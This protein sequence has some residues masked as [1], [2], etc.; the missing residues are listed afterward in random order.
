MTKMSAG[1]F[2]TQSRLGFI[3]T[4]KKRAGYTRNNVFS[5]LKFK[6]RRRL[7]EESIAKGREF[8][9]KLIYRGLRLGTKPNRMTKLAAGVRRA[10]G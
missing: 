2:H 6:K 7:R 10:L 4:T 9:E 8:Y 1:R 3:N 5:G